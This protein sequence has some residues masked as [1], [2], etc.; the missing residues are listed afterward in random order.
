[1]S[2]RNPNGGNVRQFTPQQQAQI[3]D[4]HDGLYITPSF[5]QMVTAFQVTPTDKGIAGGVPGTITA[6]EVMLELYL[7]GG[8]KMALNANQS[9]AFL[10][11]IGLRQRLV[12]PVG[13]IQ[14]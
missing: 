2:N 6:G 8:Q 5:P 13:S 14:M 4:L 7:M 12:E 9:D 10:T 11:M 3:I 1:M